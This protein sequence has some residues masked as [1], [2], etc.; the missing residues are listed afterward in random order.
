MC[1]RLLIVCVELLLNVHQL[2]V[3][4]PDLPHFIRFPLEWAFGNAKRMTPKGEFGAAFTRALISCIDFNGVSNDTR[5]IMSRLMKMTHTG[6]RCDWVNNRKL[7]PRLIN[8]KCLHGGLL[9]I[10]ETNCYCSVNCVFLK[11]AVIYLGLLFQIANVRMLVSVC[12]IFQ[13][14]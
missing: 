10:I 3:P 13:D 8:S 5:S 4:C 1:A 12:V 6:K 14:I 7:S 9:I 2:I 11:A